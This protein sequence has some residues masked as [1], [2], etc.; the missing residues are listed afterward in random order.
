M[1][2]IFGPTIRSYGLNAKSFFTMRRVEL[3]V[4][5]VIC[6]IFLGLL[7]VLGASSWPKISSSAFTMSTDV[8]ANFA[9]GTCEAS[10]F[11]L[12]QIGRYDSIRFDSKV[13]GRFEIESAVPAHCIVVVKRLKSLTS[14]S[15]TVYRLTS[16]MSDHTPVLFNVFEDWNEES[17]ILHISFDSIRDSIRTQTADSQVPTL[18]AG[19][20]LFALILLNKP[21][22]IKSTPRPSSRWKFA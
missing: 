2:F 15:G 6:S 10:I 11:D 1:S 14:L 5:S 22:R 17:V 18:D 13:M 4:I 16:S 8:L 9:S 3:I 21:F 7:L 20:Q 12:I 19:Y